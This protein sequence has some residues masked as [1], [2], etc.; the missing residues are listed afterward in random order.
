MHIIAIKVSN[1]YSASLEGGEPCPRTGTMTSFLGLSFN[2]LISFWVG[3][4]NASSLPTA[5]SRLVPSG[6]LS[7]RY[8]S[9]L[10]RVNLMLSAPFSEKCKDS[11][12]S[13]PFLGKKAQSVPALSTSQVIELSMRPFL[14]NIEWVPP[15]TGDTEINK[16]RNDKYQVQ[17]C[18]LPKYTSKAGFA[19]WLQH[20]AA[21][22]SLQI[23][24][25]TL[26]S[27]VTCGYRAFQM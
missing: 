10:P 15:A 4:C 18:P 3:H 25:L 7:N 19:S 24:S 14:L 8:Q 13:F 11:L 16:T 20:S 21:S 22:E 26:Q 23:C 6:L 5:H 12:S 1:K 27:L 9:Q 17:G 2:H